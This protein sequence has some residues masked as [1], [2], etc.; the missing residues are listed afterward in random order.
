MGLVRAGPRGDA[1]QDRGAVGLRPYKRLAN[2]V[3]RMEA[4]LAIVNPWDIPDPAERPSVGR[5]TG[6]GDLWGWE[7]Q[8]PVGMPYKTGVLWVSALQAV[9][10]NE[11][12]RR[13]GPMLAMA[14]SSLG[15]PPLPG[16]PRRGLGALWDRRGLDPL[17][18][19]P[20]GPGALW[21]RPTRSLL[22][23]HL[24]DVRDAPPFARHVEFAVGRPQ[25][26]LDG[27]EQ[28]LQVPLLLEPL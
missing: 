17:W 16:D 2:E 3:L 24:I 1:L 8:G 23:A 10:A 26:T 14:N 5:P 19:N 18:G 4:T 7:E 15:R 20:R 11:I 13:M 21:G 6:L 28:Y 12:L 9:L 25:L 27:E 22:P